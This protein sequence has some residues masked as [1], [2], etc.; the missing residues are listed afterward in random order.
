RLAVISFHSLEDRMVKRFL[1]KKSQGN[2]LPI[3]LPVQY[4]D[5]GAELSLVGKAIRPGKDEVA[6]NVRSRSATLRIAEKIIA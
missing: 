5:T 1:R 4:E 6:K 2:R 3:D